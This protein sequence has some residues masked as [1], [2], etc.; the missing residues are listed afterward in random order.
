VA[1]A[2]VVVVAA[3]AAA[4]EEE[5]AVEVVEEAAVAAVDA[6]SCLKFKIYCFIFIALKIFNQ[7]TRCIVI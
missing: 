1:A 4:V 3:A 7:N 6:V 5:E 2:V